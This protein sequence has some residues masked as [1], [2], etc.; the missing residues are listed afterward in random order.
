MKILSLLTASVV[1]FPFVDGSTLVK[2]QEY[3]KYCNDRYGFCIDYPK[4]IGIEP[5]PDNN[6]GRRFYDRNGF[7]MTASGINNVTNETSQSEMQSQK[8]DFNVITYQTTGKN[9]FILSGY[10]DNNILYIKTYVG[11]GSIN[12]LY[13]QYPIYLKA[14]YDEVVIRIS[15]SFKPGSINTIN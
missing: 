3:S 5:A 10:K 7:F 11:N 8:K 1:T 9:W 4:D 12:H 15:R 2:A 13:I 6:D 14:E